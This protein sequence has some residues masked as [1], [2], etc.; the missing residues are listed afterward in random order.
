MIT[1]DHICEKM[2]LEA[3]EADILSSVS[4][5]TGIR[6]QTTRNGISSEVT[7]NGIASVAQNKDAAITTAKQLFCTCTSR[8][9]KSKIAKNNELIIRTFKVEADTRPAGT[10]T[11]SILTN[12]AASG[13][14]LRVAKVP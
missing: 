13:L 4:A 2:N 3:S 6:K 12:S 9:G 8:M 5:S 11:P 14:S 1:D 7:N 10:D